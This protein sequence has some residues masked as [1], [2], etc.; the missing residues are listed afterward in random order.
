MCLLDGLLFGNLGIELGRDLLAEVGATDAAN[1]VK[2]EKDCASPN[3]QDEKEAHDARIGEWQVG[4][5]NGV[6]HV[7]LFPLG[8]IP[9]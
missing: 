1:H 8:A 3:K 9:L 4:V 5:L 7:I 6:Q 2:N